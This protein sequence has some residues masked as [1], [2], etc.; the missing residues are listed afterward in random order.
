MYYIIDNGLHAHGYMSDLQNSIL[1]SSIL[2]PILLSVFNSFSYIVCLRRA[3]LLS[4]VSAACD[5]ASCLITFVLPNS[6]YFLLRF[7]DIIYLVH[8]QYYIIWPIDNNFVFEFDNGTCCRFGVDKKVVN[9]LDLAELPR[10][11]CGLRRIPS[12]QL[13]SVGSFERR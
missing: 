10:Q 2:S 1:I 5:L 3:L 8:G 6:T 4:F 11:L 7:L 12:Y 13:F 9:L